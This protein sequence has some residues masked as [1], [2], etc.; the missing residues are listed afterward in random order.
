MAKNTKTA[1][2]KPATPKALFANLTERAKTAREQAAA[3]RA[4]VVQFNQDNLEALKASGRI[5]STGG[6]ALV[7]QV[8]A[9]AKRQFATVS[10]S[11]KVLADVKSPKE[12][13]KLQ[14]EQAKSYF[15]ASRADSKALGQSVVKLAGEIVEPLKSRGAAVKA[16][17]ARA[18]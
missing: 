18:A 1:A 17:F 16:Q 15:E 11:R 8:V 13:V 6:K 7:E 2:A 14:R 5:A 3:R 12:L 4:E 10:E 9:N